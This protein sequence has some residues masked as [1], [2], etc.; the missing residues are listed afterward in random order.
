M[1]G[2]KDGE[3]NLWNSVGVEPWKFGPGDWV[4][5]PG[6]PNHHLRIVERH[7]ENNV[8]W[9]KIFDTRMNDVGEYRWRQANELESKSFLYASPTP[10]QIPAIL[11]RTES[12]RGIEWS[13]W[14]RTDCESIQRWI[15]TGNE[16]DR[17]SPQV[18]IGVGLAAVITLACTQPNQQR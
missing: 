14:V 12:C 17:W 6:L 15:H 7:L 13:A 1:L 5:E 16:N 9:Y 8:R 2:W 10:D 18:L 11:E 4:V 3:G